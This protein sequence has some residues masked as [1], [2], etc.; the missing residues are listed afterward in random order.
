M[1]TIRIDDQ[2]GHE[3]EGD[4]EGV[5]GNIWREEMEGRNSVIKIQY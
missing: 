1:C 4:Q 3:F 5:Y 2:K